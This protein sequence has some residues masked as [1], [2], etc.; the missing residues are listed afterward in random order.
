MRRKI[1][2][3]VDDKFDLLIIG[4]GIHGAVL[5]WQAALAGLSVALIEKED[6]GH[7]TSSNSQK[8]IHG[9]IR[10]LQGFDIGRTRQSLKARHRLMHLAPHLVH[11]LACI[12]PIYGHGLKGIETMSLGLRLY[13]LIGKSRNKNSDSSKFIPDGR[14]LTVSETCE[15]IPHLHRKDLQGAAKWYDAYCHNTER[16]VLA[17]IKSAYK[18]GSVVSNYVKA[19]TLT[20]QKDSGTVIKAHDKIN[21]EYIEIFAKKVI[22][23][24][25]PWLYDVLD[26]SLT[27]IKRKI[28]CAVGINIITDKL[29]SHDMAVGLKSYFNNKSSL[30]FISPWRG[31]SI[32]GTEWF[33]NDSHPDKLI[34]T[35]RQCLKLIEGFN[36]AYRPANL[37]LDDVDHVH[38]GLV[39]CKDRKNSRDKVSLLNHFKILDHKKEGLEQVFSTVGVKYTTAADVA[40]KTLRYV[41]PKIRK[42]SISSLPRLAG[43]EIDNFTTFQT[44]MKKTL[45][46]QEVDKDKSTQLIFN[47][48]REAEKIIEFATTDS[49]AQ[50]KDKGTIC[51]ILRGETLF[52]VREEMAQKLSDVVFRRTQL[53]SAGLPSESSLTAVS[54]LMA[55]ELGWDEIRRKSELNDVKAFYPSFLSPAS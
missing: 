30:Y 19:I 43:G 41:F 23:C 38:V 32:I 35:E 48:G 24:S 7:A 45:N 55:K 51:D 52:A 27:K 20:P 50:R 33:K 10:Y 42:M 1:A 53:G 4:G 21:D 5:S 12:M 11:P 22:N 26:S 8:I 9:G 36:D 46:S 17:F 39:P 31:K 34:G 47:Y 18:R 14:I 2:N 13:D 15:L 28:K 40:E 54:G 37:T 3:L 44:A 6:F 49:P 16:L 29:F 25:G